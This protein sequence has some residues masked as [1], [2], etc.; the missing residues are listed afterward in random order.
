MKSITTYHSNGTKTEERID[1]DCV[2][3]YRQIP[4]QARFPI[5]PFI[6]KKLTSMVGAPFGILIDIDDSS[7]EITLN[8]EYWY[9]TV[10][11]RWLQAHHPKIA[12]R[13]AL[14]KLA[15]GY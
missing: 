10:G 1:Y 13:I 5:T 15:Q 12:A 3:R 14:E 7:H 6:R 8:T 4:M 11:I 9:V 2:I